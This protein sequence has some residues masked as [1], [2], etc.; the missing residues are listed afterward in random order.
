MN[1]EIMEAVKKR[2]QGYS[3]VETVEEY[4]VV[5]GTL[6][7]V[8]KRVTTKDVPPDMTAAKIL[9]DGE[10]METLTDEELE[11]EKERLIRE[12]MSTEG[13]AREPQ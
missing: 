7:L 5:D 6:E 2:A 8:K 3:S 9:L 4:A 13:R 11:A 12:L 1:D 10:G